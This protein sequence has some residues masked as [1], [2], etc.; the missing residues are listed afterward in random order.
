MGPITAMAVVSA[1]DAAARFRPSSSASAYLGLTPRRYEL[2]EISRN[3]R[4]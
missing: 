1:F 3:G 4:A 2:R